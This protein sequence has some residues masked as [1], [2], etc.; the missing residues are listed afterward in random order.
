M[1]SVFRGSR[2]EALNREGYDHRKENHRRFEYKSKM[3]RTIVLYPYMID[4]KGTIHIRAMVKTKCKG[5]Q[6]KMKRLV[7]MGIFSK[8]TLYLRREGS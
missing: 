2:N 6:A 5:Y 4:E 8:D 1:G 3:T 7:A